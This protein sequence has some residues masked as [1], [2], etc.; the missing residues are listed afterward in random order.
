MGFLLH[1]TQ[2]DPEGVYQCVFR[3]VATLVRP[4]VVITSQ[5]AFYAK[6][7]ARTLP[8]AP[9]DPV[10]AA[11]NA[12]IDQHKLVVVRLSDRTS[13][14]LGELS[15]ASAPSSP[16]ALLPRLSTRNWRRYGDSATKRV[17]SGPI[18]L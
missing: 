9:A 4:N 3:C 15:R 17:P 11:K 10:L 18:A 5:P 1:R 16:I 12:F 6:A 8:A 13:S 14:R 2:G 7:D